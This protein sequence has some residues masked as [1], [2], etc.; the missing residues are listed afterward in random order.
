MMS[1][2][3]G[4]ALTIRRTD[5]R[6]IG[7]VALAMRRAWPFHQFGQANDSRSNNGATGCTDTCLQFLA[8]LVKGIWYTHDALRTRVGHRNPWSGLTYGE[9]SALATT[10]N[11]GYRVELGLSF[12]QIVS[13]VRTRG[14]VMI[15]EMYGQHPSWR[16]FRYFGRLASA[17]PN[18]FAK[19]LGKAG[20]TQL[21]PTFRHAIVIVAIGTLNGAQ[22]AYIF[23]PNHNSPARPEDPPYDVVTMSQLR[24]L[25]DTYR[26][27]NGKTYA[28]H[29]TRPIKAAA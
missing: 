1:R 4:T 19:P 2:L 20:R 22:V 9:V 12:E 5:T 18:G 3:L 27:T 6:S 8:L 14:P 10:L 16:G 15:G 26:A 17:V 7:S 21:G 29:P 28:L 24:R 23:E 11:L 25:L 13:L